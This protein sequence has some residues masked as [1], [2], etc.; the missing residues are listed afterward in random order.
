[1]DLILP[2]ILFV[3][4]L[5]CIVKGGDW[6]VDAA[7]WIAEVSGIP[8]V[9]VGAT[10]VSI[11]TTLPEIIVSLIAA[12]QGKADMA[13]GNAVGSVTANTGLILGLSVLFAPLVLRR[14]DYWL[15]SLLMVTA[16]AVLYAFSRS[17][18]LT[19]YGSLLLIAIFAVF[20]LDN[21]RSAVTAAE[22]HPRETPVRGEVR[23]NVIQFILGTAGIVIGAQLLVDNGSLLAKE[24]GVPEGIISVTFIA[25][26]TSLPELVTAIT[27]L[28]KKQGSLSAGNII[29]A[30]L[31]DTTLILPL[32][33]WLSGKSLSLS[34]QSLTLDLPA[35]LL[36]LSVAVI[37][38]LIRSKFMRWQGALLLALYGGY[39]YLVLA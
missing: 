35:S 23:R 10:I 22:H 12:F 8:K 29:G 20:M 11:A 21:L 15:K 2:I 6:F 37:P 1:M 34:V 19:S 26:G 14:K 28:V 38:M 31:I 36:I 32:C 39:I 3:F 4:G 18:E 24:L 30:N 33:N 13:V 17:G 25:V 9:V 27:S 5:V 16:M 7:A